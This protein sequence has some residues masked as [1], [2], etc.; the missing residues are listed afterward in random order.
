M[1]FLL[2]AYRY[3]HN[4]TCGQVETAILD[5]TEAYCFRRNRTLA[6]D[7]EKIFRYTTTGNISPGLLYVP[8]ILYAVYLVLDD[9]SSHV[10]R[11][12]AWACRLAP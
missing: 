1:L 6:M 4:R 2:S 5:W 12:E 7:N 9:F 8:F 3:A 11:F 10:V